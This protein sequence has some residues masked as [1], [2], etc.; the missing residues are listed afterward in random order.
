MQ[1]LLRSCAL[2]QQPG[3]RA[4][5][6]HRA[7]WTPPT[8]TPPPPPPT[9]ARAPAGCGASYRSLATAAQAAC[10]ANVHVHF[11]HVRTEEQSAAAA[12]L[13][14]CGDGQAQGQDAV[15]S[16]E[17]RLA[18]FAADFAELESVTA[19]IVDG[20]AWRARAR[21]PRRLPSRCEPCRHGRCAA[22]L[23][24]AALL[25]PAWPACLCGSPFVDSS[26]CC[27]PARRR[28][29][30]GGP[31]DGLGGAPAAAW[32]TAA[33][34]AAA[35]AAGPGGPQGA[36]VQAGAAAGA[37]GAGAAA[38][39]H[40][41]LPLAA[42][43]ARPCRWDAACLSLPCMARLRPDCCRA[44]GLGRAT[45][46]VL[47]CFD[48]VRAPAPPPT[49]RRRPAL[50]SHGPGPHSFPAGCLHAAGRAEQPAADCAGHPRARR[51]AQAAADQ[52]AAQDGPVC[53]EAGAGGLVLLHCRPGS[54]RPAGVG[55]RHRPACA[56]MSCA[57]V[58][59]TTSLLH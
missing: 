44:Q 9:H 1:Q 48:F 50:R 39:Q 31:G 7:P 2:Q 28:A 23:L 54:G 41:R 10:A 33:A 40:L 47:L 49:L 21:A 12:G 57:H 51:P 38:R 19:D 3:G 27:C 58:P 18:V 55:C 16:P 34:G 13:L 26:P 29:V 6:A 53:G 15:A 22:G 25:D 30:A 8:H 46:P 4:P 20:G 56:G 43:H 52:L 11:L 35:A 42:H 24:P 45:R 17:A 14:A 36:V 59:P 32:P 37:A 5:A